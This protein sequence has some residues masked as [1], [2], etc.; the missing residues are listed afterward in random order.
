MTISKKLIKILSDEE[1]EKKQKDLIKKENEWRE[2]I[3]GFRN[4]QNPH[5]GTSA[6]GW[7]DQ[8]TFKTNIWNR[9]KS[10]S[11]YDETRFGPDPLDCVIDRMGRFEGIDFDNIIEHTFISSGH[12]PQKNTLTMFDLNEEAEKIYS[13]IGMQYDENIKHTLPTQYAHPKNINVQYPGNVLPFHHDFYKNT[14]TELD[15]NFTKIRKFIIF[16]EDW[17]PGH[18]WAIGNTTYSHW[19][20]GDCFTWDWIH[21]PHG[22]ANIGEENRYI[23]YLIGYMTEKS[24]NFYNNGNKDMRYFLS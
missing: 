19:K 11:N 7:S 21:M 10:Y 23:L 5:P 16:L 9:V 8:E 20:Q 2:K 15:F 3:I 12:I 6:R 13:Y 1:W 18:I 24:Y 4:G 22:T 17:K 14:L